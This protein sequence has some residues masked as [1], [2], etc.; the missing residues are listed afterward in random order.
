[1]RVIGVGV[2]IQEVGGFARVLSCIDKNLPFNYLG[3]SVGRSMTRKNNWQCLVD[4]FKNK[5]SYSI[6]R[7]LSFGGKLVICKSVHG[8]LGSYMFSLYKAPN[9]IIKNLVCIRRNFFWGG[10]SDKRKVEWVAWNKVLNLKALGFHCK[11][12]WKFKQ[13]HGSLWTEVIKALHGSVGNF[14]RS[15]LAK[16]KRRTRGVI[17]N[18][19]SDLNKINV[20]L[21]G[22][23]L[24]T[25]VS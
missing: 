13:D 5:L 3:L 23:F 14:G 7:C 17:S 20:E 2:S 18:I 8:H 11:W 9:Q 10:N 4:K 16:N 24:R 25:N 19:N 1:M 15:R 6:A 21:D 22:M 12:W